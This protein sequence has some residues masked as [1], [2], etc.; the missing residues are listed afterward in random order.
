[1]TDSE[2][3]HDPFEEFTDNDT[4]HRTYNVRWAVWRWHFYAGMLVTPIILIL[5]I[6][7][8]L[9]V[10]DSE[11]NDWYYDHLYSVESSD[12]PQ[13][14][15]Q[16]VTK[17]INE[18]LS[19]LG[20]TEI[21]SLYIPKDPSRSIYAFC[22][23]EPGYYLWAFAHPNTG[24]F[25][26]HYV[27]EA[28]FMRMMEQLH[29]RLLVP[30]N[31][32]LDEWVGD[33]TGAIVVELTTSWCIILVITGLYLWW[34]SSWRRMPGVW[35]PRLRAKPYQFWRDWHAVP[36]VYLSALTVIVLLTGL[37][38]STY[39][40]D[41]FRRTEQWAADDNHEITAFFEAEEP[42]EPNEP[43]LTPD[44][45]LQMIQSDRHDQNIVYTVRRF[46]GDNR[47]AIVST[48]NRHTFAPTETRYLMVDRHAG[49]VRGEASWD[50]ANLLSKTMR[51]A[52]PL[53]TGSIFGP[54]TQFLAV[55]V[56]LGL[57]AASAT[58]ATMWWT[59]R[60][61]GKFGLPKAPRSHLPPV[62]LIVIILCLLIVL[63]T[64]GMSMLAVLAIDI[65]WKIYRHRL[66]RKS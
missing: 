37:V 45:L 4:A 5:A 33:D 1:M 31:R 43:L 46:E 42:I 30:K 41:A 54:T 34:P 64:T 27:Y 17:N 53:H 56:C 18:G 26:G 50:K 8:T 39:F 11:F 61:T 24:E 57:I 55:L 29:R 35:L 13:A 19:P 44:D 38:F 6:T 23:A 20:D 36:S 40:G 63:P 21:T 9:L 58:G 49:E 51:L 16:V 25:I 28:S 10:F 3:S 52:Y 48:Y 62:G 12:S 14:S 15:L 65:P 2:R 22:R 60:P 47:L 59:R 66:L 32:V 7:G